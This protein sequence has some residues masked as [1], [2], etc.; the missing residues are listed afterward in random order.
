MLINLIC[1]KMIMMHPHLIVRDT[2]NAAWINIIYIT[3]IALILYAITIKIY[4]PKY[5]TVIDAAEKAGGKP[6]KIITGIISVIVLL[7]NMSFIVRAYPETVKTVLLPQIQIPMITTVYLFTAA[8]GAYIGIESN[9][10]IQA[11]FMPA[12]GA[13][14]IG[15]FL[16]SMPY[17]KLNNLM[18]V[19]GNGLYSIF[20]KGSIYVSIFSD[21]IILN[22][23]SPYINIK[24]DIKSSGKTAI[25]TSGIVSLMIIGTY[26][27]VYPYPMSSEFIL[28]VYQ[29]TRIVRIGTFFQRLESLFQFIWS[30]GIYLYTSLYIAVIAEVIR[31]SFGLRYSRPLIFP[32]AATVGAMSFA[33]EISTGLETTKLIMISMMIFAFCVPVLLGIF[34]KARKTDV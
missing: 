25:I 30:I 2:A 16:L 22:F 3:V 20:A 8:V 33:M 23:L 14:L 19:F 5:G 4:D 21:V 28:P 31:E 10:R 11:I 12:A 17:W 13:L 1:I 15:F 18:P 29:I 34:L 32:I 27:L 24:R 7:T 6:L 26:N 9:A